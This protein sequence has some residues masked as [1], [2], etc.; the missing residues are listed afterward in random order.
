[1]MYAVK[2]SNNGIT[3]VISPFPLVWL[4]D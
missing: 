4:E 1:M 2:Q 3:F